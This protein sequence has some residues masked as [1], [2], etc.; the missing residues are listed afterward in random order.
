MS[1]HI[2]S[3]LTRAVLAAVWITSA[4]YGAITPWGDVVPPYSGADPWMVSGD[5][6]VADSNDGTLLLESGSS[7]T[8]DGKGLVAY[9][10]DAWGLIQVYHPNTTLTVLD[11][12]T[13]GYA[14]TGTLLVDSGADVT[15]TNAGIGV[16]PGSSGTVTVD[17]AGSTWT[18]SGSVFV[19]GYGTG[20]LVVSDGGQVDIGQILYVGGF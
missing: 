4:A 12:L 15:S 7:V 10:P 14:G 20:E 18:N 16:K 9:G 2:A 19:G 8:V 13:I 6:R 1:R 5:L 11:S 17:G 3:Y